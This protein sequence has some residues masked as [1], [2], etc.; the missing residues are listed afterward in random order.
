MTIAVSILTALCVAVMARWL[1]T[2]RPET[3][4]FVQRLPDG[5]VP[6]FDAPPPPAS[7]S[8]PASSQ[9]TDARDDAPKGSG[10]DAADLVKSGST[11]AADSD[12]HSDDGDGDDVP[13]AAAD[14]AADAETASD[15]EAASEADATD[16][17]EPAADG[18]DPADEDQDGEG[19][20]R[21]ADAT[22]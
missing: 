4:P 10:T 6:D 8:S 14:E 12:E 5:S 17:A 16:Q 19:E 11:V 3:A 20:A 21:E 22:Q 13:D 15:A 9:D 7:L 18:D 2:G 1:L